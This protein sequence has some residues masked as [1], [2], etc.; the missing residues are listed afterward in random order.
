ME[1]IPVYELEMDRADLRWLRKH[2]GTDRT[3]PAQL[4]ID[5][6]AWPISIGYRGRYSRW[7]DKPSYDIQFHEDRQMEGHARLHL[8]A[9]Y[10]D[11]SMLRARLAMAVFS[12]LGVPTPEIW[13]VWLAL[14]GKPL[15]L[16]QALESIDGAWFRRQGLPD[17][18]IYYAVGRHGNFG[19]IDADTDQPKR[20]LA[21]GYEKCHP[22]DDDCSDL[23]ELIRR[24]TLPD[25]SQFEGTIDQVVDVETFLRWLIGVEFMSHT[26]GLVQN[27]AL[28][29]NRSKPWRISPWD[30]DGTWGRI[31]NGRTI[32][33]DY[34]SLGTGEDNYL[35]VRLLHTQ[36]WRNRYLEM[37]AHSLETV[38]DQ[39]HI[40]SMLTALYNEIRPHAA[41]DPIKRSGH[42][43]FVG[44][45]ARIRR[46]VRERTAVARE[47]LA[48]LASR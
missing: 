22:E 18:T 13:S 24:I 21:L 8:N 29:R 40:D 25:D 35:A 17:G 42:A 32:E 39:D 28:F 46:Y 14:N 15:G 38:L 7:F 1:P 23:E 33:A 45:P 31:P 4:R 9:A 11:P 36:R 43:T 34:M 47:R 19:L 3:F 48:G 27:Y 37:W 44:E 26:D 10:R 12:E 16:Y 2:E 5:G 41:R 30:C 20:D 6:R